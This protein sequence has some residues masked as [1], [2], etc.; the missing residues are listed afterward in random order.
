MSKTTE[1]QQLQS[2]FLVSYIPPSYIIQWKII[3][4]ISF[5]RFFLDIE[6]ML[7]EVKGKLLA[8]T[9]YALC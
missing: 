8:F 9:G 5:D 2:K 7:E 6:A 4:L 1:S 3:D